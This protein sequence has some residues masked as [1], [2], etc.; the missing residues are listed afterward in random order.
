MKLSG[1]AG[2]SWTGRLV[3][4][5]ASIAVVAAACSEQTS[6]GPTGDGSPTASDTTWTFTDARGETITLPEKP[7]RIVAWQDNI[8]ALWDYGIRPV[9]YW[10]WQTLEDN[11]ALKGE[12]VSGIK[13]I[14]EDPTTYNI[15]LEKLASLDP[16]LVVTYHFVPPVGKETCCWRSETEETAVTAIVPWVAL[17]P[18]E[19]QSRQSDNLEWHRAFAASLG[20]TETT[21]G[22]QATA[23]YEAAVAAVEAAA[24]ANPDVQVLGMSVYE[25]VIYL[26]NPEIISNWD[27]QDYSA[28]GVS[29][30]GPTD[31]EATA[32]YD[33]WWEDLSWET[34]KS[35]IDDD[36][37][38]DIILLD[39]RSTDSEAGVEGNPIWATLDAVEAGQVGTWYATGMSRLKLWTQHLQ[40]LA[41]LIESAGP[42]N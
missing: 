20:A 10:G 1:K 4:A 16:D 6:A 2:S 31:P 17:G 5:I 28:W 34:A 23:D 30:T 8:A 24:A 37:S 26:A 12:D 36:Y 27:F 40:E 18:T 14:T 19:E 42:V 39:A 25:D 22:Q 9:A 13:N 21:E 33:G 3:V 35:K 11:P 7:E 29:L 15:D 32:D 41:A 38:A